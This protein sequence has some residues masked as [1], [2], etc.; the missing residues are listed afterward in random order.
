M[1]SRRPV[2]SSVGCL[3]VAM[4]LRNTPLLALF[5]IVISGCVNA[6]TNNPELITVHSWKKGTASISKQTL[7]V[8]LNW[9]LNQYELHVSDLSNKR[10]FRLTFHKDFFNTPRRQAIPCWVA[11]FNETTLDPKT[12][13]II[14]GHN[15]LSVEG[16]GV[17]DYFPREEWAIY[18]CPV[19]QPQKLFDG[20]L[21]PMRAERRFLIENMLVTLKVND[22]REDTKQNTLASLDLKV[23]FGPQ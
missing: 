22:Y 3:S 21:Y 18:L 9:D 20:L 8:S 16:P 23:N 19:E 5:M 4:N 11:T 15:L 2:N 13:G 10:N 7:N 17:G 14:V 12:G 1:K 6:Q